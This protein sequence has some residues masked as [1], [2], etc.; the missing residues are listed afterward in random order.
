M[1]AARFVVPILWVLSATE[2]QAA[3]LVA[4]RDDQQATGRLER[5]KIKIEAY[6][7]TE[8]AFILSLPAPACLE[9]EDEYDKVDS[10]KRIHVFSMDGEILGKLRSSVGKTIRVSG[11]AFGEQT[12]HHHAPIVM[13]VTKVERIH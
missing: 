7:L 1:R 10:T 13:N 6:R 5:L 8:T 11:S 12:I 2:A 4:N 9:G 3:C